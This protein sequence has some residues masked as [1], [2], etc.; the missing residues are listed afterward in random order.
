MGWLKVIA[1]NYGLVTKLKLCAFKVNRPCNMDSDLINI[2]G[3]VSEF[4]HA[5]LYKMEWNMIQ[6]LILTEQ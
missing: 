3:F 4:L 6:E 1:A 5:S 2:G